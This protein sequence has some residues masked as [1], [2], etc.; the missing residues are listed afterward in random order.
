MIA[1][2]AV[3]I[4]FGLVILTAPPREM[5]IRT[6]VILLLMIA[7]LGLNELSKGLGLA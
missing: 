6:W 2:S 5:T 7:V 3:I 1:A 4:V